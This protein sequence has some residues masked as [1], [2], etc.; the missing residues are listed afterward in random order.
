MAQTTS[1]TTNYTKEVLR[2]VNKERAKAGLPAYTTTQSLT[3]AANQ[4]AKEITTQFSH[5]RPNGSRFFTV[6][7]E[8]G[9]PFMAAGENIAYGQKTP[10]EV[11]TSWMSSPGH[12]RNILSSRFRKIGIGLAQKGNQ[13][14]WTQDFT[15]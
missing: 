3:T 9:I 6:L 15:N 10:Q 2:L 7:R 5:T 4:R 8:N 14:Y 13:N 12:K 1:D 11:V